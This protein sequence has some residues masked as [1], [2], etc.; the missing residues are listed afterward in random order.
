[1][2]QTS[3]NDNQTKIREAVFKYIPKEAEVSRIEYEG[4]RIAI[5]SKR[6]G[7]LLEHSSIIGSVV[8]AIRKR[9]VIR[10]D[11]TVRLSEP[12]PRSVV[13]LEKGSE[14]LVAIESAGRHFGHKVEETIWEK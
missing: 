4:P 6:P 11:P 7:I 1:M 2:V 3:L 12:E 10:S 14:V 8:S 13:A 9:I 5:Y